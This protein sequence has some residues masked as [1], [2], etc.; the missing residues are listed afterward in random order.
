MKVPNDTDLCSICGLF[1]R[2][3]GVQ[4]DA[5]GGH[6]RSNDKGRET[7][8]ADALNPRLMAFL[9]E[10]Q[11][12][13]QEAGE[14]LWMI[15]QLERELA[16]AVVL[17]RRYA[18]KCIEQTSP[19]ATRRIEP[20]LV[21]HATEAAHL[22]WLDAIEEAAKAAKQIADRCDTSADAGDVNHDRHHFWGGGAREV[23][24]AIRALK[25]SSKYV[26]QR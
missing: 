22:V 20:V 26:G 18:Q 17:K 14:S 24:H 16:A 11:E 1:K 25:E 6:E 21:E 15:Q 3:P 19:S 4:G 9:R 5:C 8:R 23:E 12:A 13:Y 7:P 2:E 10:N